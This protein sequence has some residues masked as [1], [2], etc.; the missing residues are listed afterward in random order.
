MTRA[1][2]LLGIAALAL[3]IA[4]GMGVAVKATRSPLA[5]TT[6]ASGSS[7]PCAE[8]S[9]EWRWNVPGSACEAKAD[10]N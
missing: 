10:A 4:G 7:Q 2:K 5:V 1:Q 3:M 9:F 6:L 8:G